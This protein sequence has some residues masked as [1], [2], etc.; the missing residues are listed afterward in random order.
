MVVRC[1]GASSTCPAKF[2]ATKLARHVIASFVLLNSSSTHGAKRDIVFVFIGPACELCFQRLLACRILPV[3]VVPAL[4]AE[5]GCALFACHLPSFFII[6][7]CMLA[8][9][10][11]RAPSDQWVRVKC[12]LS[13]EFLEFFRKVSPITC[14]KDLNY[15]LI[16]DRLLTL[17]V[18]AD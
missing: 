18:E 13:L 16:R 12:F 9:A 5:I 6:C 1:R 15:L 17:E 3:P 8:A 2:V 11:I 14:C 7:S 4:E 10:W